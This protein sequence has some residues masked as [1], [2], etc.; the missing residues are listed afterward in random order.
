[1]IMRYEIDNYTT[2]KQKSPQT[3][4]DLVDSGYVRRIPEDPFHRLSADL[5]SG[6]CGDSGG[7]SDQPR[8]LE[9]T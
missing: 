7:R 8:N 9:R 5:A 6:G 2:D 1:M 3:L 4:Q